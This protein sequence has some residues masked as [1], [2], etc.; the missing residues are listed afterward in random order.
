MS[1]PSPGGVLIIEL[2]NI[3]K[4]YNYSTVLDEV[5]LVLEKGECG[6][7]FGPNGAGKTTLLRIAAGLERQDAGRVLF[8][9]KELGEPENRAHIMRRLGL[10]SHETMLYEHLTARENLEFFGRLYGMGRDE[11]EDRADSLLERF[12]LLHRSHD[13]ISRFSRG[14]KQRLA[15]ARA[16]VHRP[17]VILMDEPFTGLDESSARRLVDLLK[18]SLGKGLTAMMVTH[19]IERGWELADKVMIL[20]RGKIRFQAGR[21]EW[22]HKDFRDEY[23]RLTGEDRQ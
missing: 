23:A 2:R 21:E 10:I 3:K 8:F 22:G 16:L 6:V 13:R 17:D 20:H 5:S 19:N 12:A 9:G 4:R 7:I 15:V 14:M 18:D 11:A 1:L